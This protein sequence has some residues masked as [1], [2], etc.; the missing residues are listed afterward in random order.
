MDILTH[1]WVV[2]GGR[3]CYH[4]SYMKH[5]RTII[6]YYQCHHNIYIYY[7]IYIIYIY[8]IHYP[9]S[10][11]QYL[12]ELLIIPI[13]YHCHCLSIVVRSYHGKFLWNLTGHPFIGGRKARDLRGALGETPTDRLQCAYFIRIGR[14]VSP[15][16]LLL[17]LLL[18]VS[19]S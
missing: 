10:I 7:N 4:S 6:I 16:F 18:S 14:V 12:W 19:L 13:Y 1:I 17:K 5:L 9:L 8:I 2:L 15:P 11:I 3:C